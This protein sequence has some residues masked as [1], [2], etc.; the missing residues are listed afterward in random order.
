M[1]LSQLL[2]FVF[3][4]SHRLDLQTSIPFL[5]FIFNYKYPQD[6]FCWYNSLLSYML[7]H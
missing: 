6:S 5:P 7:S 3:A 4:Y 1:Y 2:Q